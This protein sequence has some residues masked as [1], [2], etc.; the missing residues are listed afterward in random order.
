[1]IK[2]N[3]FYNSYKNKVNFSLM[4]G[5]A[6]ASDSGLINDTLKIKVKPV[7]LKLP[8][9]NGTLKLRQLNERIQKIDPQQT[10]PV[11]I[12]KAIIEEKPDTN[13]IKLFDED[14]IPYVKISN[15]KTNIGPENIFVNIPD[16]KPFHKLID[17]TEIRKGSNKAINA[18]K[19]EHKEIYHL[20]KSVYKENNNN[21]REHFSASWIPGFLIILFLLLAWI[22]VFYNKVLK[23]TLRGAFNSLISNRLYR[24]K[25]IFTFW[26]NN[27]LNLLFL[28]TVGFFL[29][30][31]FIYS[32]YRI[33]SINDLTICLLF[34]VGLLII[35]TGKIF[36]V[37][38]IGVIFKESE[39]AAEYL[40]NVFLYNKTL[41][42]FLIPF[43]VVIP[44][45]PEPGT[46]F[47]LYL[48]VFT[49]F[50]LYFL[51]L[52]R[53]LTIG[54]KLNLSIFY[55]IL[56]LCTLEFFPVMILYKIFIKY[57]S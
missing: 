48:G 1:M 53:G 33:N 12:K 29:F 56:Y 2:E 43:V 31:L 17:T 21:Y 36:F 24:E 49:I 50:L 22:R 57:T 7:K 3:T 35:Y 37:R 16:Y 27:F 25:N 20:H 34:M 30:L 28:I 10:K 54:F 44:Y 5:N 47:L 26:G 42:V 51:R 40:H 32:G 41:G 11:T 6:L 45:V 8:K 4:Q 15:H 18:K 52:I 23:L 13:S 9:S 14:T 46:V 38:L 39:G 55:L 19:E